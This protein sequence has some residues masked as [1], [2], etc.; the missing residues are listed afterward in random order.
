MLTIKQDTFT[1]IGIEGRTNNAIEMSG[2][3]TIPKLWG[4][5]MQESIMGKI[6]NRA[7]DSVIAAYTEYES[8]KDGEYTFFLGSKVNSISD[9]PQGMV[10]KTVKAGSYE[11]ITT[12]TGPVWKVVQDAWQKIWQ[13]DE[14]RNYLF[15][16][17]VY[18][19]KSQNPELAQ[20]QI[21]IGVKNK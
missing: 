19:A 17:E 10:V 16:Y 9:V 20:V 3:G 13:D 6:P 5:F 21:F 7:D 1:V 14:R 8:D 4:Q 18:D 2:G 12:E 15:D 11:V